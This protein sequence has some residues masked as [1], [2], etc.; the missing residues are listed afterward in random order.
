MNWKYDEYILK[1]EKIL[2]SGYISD[3][4]YYNISFSLFQRWEYQKSA[5]YCKIGL[6]YNMEHYRL[7]EILLLI[8]Y[9]LGYTKNIISDIH[10]LYT[11]G[12]TSNILLCLEWQYY[13][14]IEDYNSALSCY[15]KGVR[16][17]PNSGMIY[18]YLASILYKQWKFTE[19]L[20]TFMI[21]LD[22]NFIY[23][24]YGIIKCIN[25]MIG[26]SVNKYFFYKYFS[27]ISK[28]SND[29]TLV[30]HIFY[31]L[32]DYKKSLQLYRESI[33]NIS[34]DYCAF[35][36]VANCLCKLWK[37]EQSKKYLLKSLKLRINDKYTLYA[38]WNTYT[39]KKDYKKALSFYL[40]WFI[41]N[42]E[43]SYIHYKIGICYFHL[44]E[45]ILAHRFL[46]KSYEYN[47]SNFMCKRYLQKSRNNIRQTNIYKKYLIKNNVEFII[48]SDVWLCKKILYRS[49]GNKDIFKK[50]I[51]QEIYPFIESN[52]DVLEKFNSIFTLDLLNDIEFHFGIDYSSHRMKLYIPLYNALNDL[53][54]NIINEICKILDLKKYFTENNCYKLDC[55]WID[56]HS[57]SLDLK[58]YELLHW[59]DIWFL[60][61][62][63]PHEEVK[64][65]GVLKSWSWRKK[66]F[67]RFK[68]PVD[69]SLFKEY[70]DTVDIENLT[71]DIKDVYRIQKKVKYY[72][73]EKWKQEIYFI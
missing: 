36:G 20:N 71:N 43:N 58:I 15:N 35:N 12:Y 61:D 13:V 27:D 38:L 45:Y 64:E 57:N 5:Q 30:A 70:F 72:C 8:Q 51:Y 56:I 17:F 34:N 47:T 62:Y 66:Y 65:Y 59:D 31:E 19:S 21:S 44:G 69:I 22:N 9:A 11:R 39:Y 33:R 52:K 2:N 10:I 48:S 24:Y 49:Q 40:T 73:Q 63:I 14:D 53:G 46:E 18:Y 16:I 50:Y 37:Y 68:S 7:K 26:V 55:I 6:K 42:S 54:F 41:N 23:S 29:I 28:F 3:E 4:L 60:P 25:N 67:C 32:W 1:S